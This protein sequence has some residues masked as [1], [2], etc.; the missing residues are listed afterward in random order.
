[1]RITMTMKSKN[2]RSILSPNKKTKQASFQSN[3]SANDDSG[4][5]PTDDVRD[6]G[7]EIGTAPDQTKTGS[8]EINIPTWVWV[9]L[10]IFVGGGGY[11]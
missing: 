10:G 7:T 6:E 1:M 2:N 4:S 8:A 5:R 3:M 9:L 11:F